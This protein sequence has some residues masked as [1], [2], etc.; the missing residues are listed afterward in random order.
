MSSDLELRHLRYFVAVAELQSF[1]KAAG[2]LGMAQ[3]PLSQQIRQLEERVGH[4]LL[5]RRPRVKLT[6][7]GAALLASARQILAHVEHS[8]HAARHVATDE[9][10]LLHVGLASSALF[11]T[12]SIALR[13]FR[14]RHPLVELRLHELHSGEQLECLRTGVVEVGITREPPTEP[15]FVT[16]ELIREQLA[17]VVPGSHAL[18]RS[19]TIAPRRL[20]DEA[21]VLFARDVAPLLYDQIQ[22]VCREAGFTPRVEQHAREWQ[23]IVALVGC[24]LG[25]SI[26]PASVATLPG[27]G[28]VVRRLRPPVPRAALFVVHRQAAPSPAALTFAEFL[29]S[30]TQGRQRGRGVSAHL[31]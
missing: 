5:E 1:T 4:T 20:T 28:A 10:T 3:P 16:H 27:R 25:V 15:G 6:A 13:R 31:E 2:R 26:A 17:A 19:A 29:V 9:R 8:L 11:T 18:A 30:S 22:S 12:L 21:F 7:S 23:T 24:G 14:R